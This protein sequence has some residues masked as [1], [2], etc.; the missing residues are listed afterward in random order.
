MNFNSE[1]SLYPTSVSLV[2]LRKCFPSSYHSRSFSRVCPL[3]SSSPCLDIE[4]CC[5]IS[6]EKIKVAFLCMW[7]LWAFFFFF[8]SVYTV[9]LWVLCLSMNI[10]TVPVNKSS[11]SQAVAVQWC[12]AWP[13]FDR[14]VWK[15]SPMAWWSLSSRSD[16]YTSLDMAAPTCQP[17]LKAGLLVCNKVPMSTAEGTS[18]LL[19]CSSLPCLWYLSTFVLS[20]PMA[21]VWCCTVFC[22]VL[23]SKCS[24]TVT[25]GRSVSCCW[26]VPP[27]L[28]ARWSMYR[29]V[30]QAPPTTSHSFLVL[31]LF[32][33]L[34]VSRSS[35]WP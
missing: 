2:L 5:F 12:G 10:V 35:H 27:F 9:S 16:S 34:Q 29:A 4:R 19:P 32:L 22:P 23:E 3:L 17:F 25:Q 20:V 15:T 26:V 30:K 28:I 11:W 21:A 1:L 18:P 33:K 6:P 14:I 13:Q 8:L 7:V 31:C 24:I